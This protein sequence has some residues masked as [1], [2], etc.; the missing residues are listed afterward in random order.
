MANP[1]SPYLTVTPSVFRANDQKKKVV[2]RARQSHMKGIFDVILNIKVCYV[3]G[4]VIPSQSNVGAWIRETESQPY[5]R[6][7]EG[8]LVLEILT[9][10]EGEYTIF[11]EYQRK[12]RNP[13][14]T[15]I[16]VYALKDDLFKLRPYKGDFHLHST[17]SDGIFTPEYTAATCRWKGFDY[18]AMTDHQK[19]VPSLTARDFI[20]DMQCDM[21][22]CPGEE[23]HLP[24]NPVH[25]VNFGG[26]GS[27]NELAY[28]DQEKYRAEVAEYMK[29]VPESYDYDTRFQVAA[30]EWAFDRIREV[31]GISLFCH[32][33]WKPMH[34]NYIGED[35]IELLMDRNRF[36]ALEVIGGFDANEA[37]RNFMA[38]A[39]WQDE[40]SKGKKMPA[41]GVSDAHH[42]DNFRCGWLYTIVFCESLSFES[43]SEAIHKEYSLA[44]HWFPD[45]VPVVIGS[46]RLTKF[47]YF[48]LREFYPRHDELCAVEGGIL[49]RYLAGEEPDAKELL[50]RKHGT[51]AEYI[52]AFWE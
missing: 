18:M 6:D 13:E 34:H 50:A 26:R 24:D 27:V 49:R 12:Y 39:R 41:V 51:V 4:V 8:N 36:D 22:A 15:A 25:I 9:P 31:G 47:A 2:I 7:E 43:I 32:P 38:L 20:E 16:S 10:R 21:L 46:F 44:V 37:E 29:T 14:N 40:K 1:H 52:N 23:V 28:G 17:G 11:I 42:C 30:S 45:D 33:Y 3:D 35:V 19:Y 5:S 48:L